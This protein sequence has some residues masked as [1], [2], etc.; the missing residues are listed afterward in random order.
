MHIDLLYDR[1]YSL[2]PTQKKQYNKNVIY[3]RSKITSFMKV[4]TDIIAGIAPSLIGQVVVMC[5]VYR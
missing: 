4:K 5:V 2:Y 3:E 1:D